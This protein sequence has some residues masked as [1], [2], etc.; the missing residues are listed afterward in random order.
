MH[1]RYNPDRDLSLSLRLTVVDSLTLRQ[2]EA[3]SI[4]EED[5]ANTHKGAHGRL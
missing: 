5:T 4:V 1:Y 3:L 2:R